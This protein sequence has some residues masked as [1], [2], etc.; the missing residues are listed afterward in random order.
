MTLKATDY[1]QQTDLKSGDLNSV[2]KGAHELWSE[3]KESLIRRPVLQGCYNRRQTVCN[4]CD[5]NE[6][7]VISSNE[8][9]AAG[10]AVKD[11]NLSRVHHVAKR[12]M[13]RYI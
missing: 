8:I 6:G 9:K 4:C 12:E 11:N 13:A 1:L 10:C 5:G 7:H 2:P 3:L